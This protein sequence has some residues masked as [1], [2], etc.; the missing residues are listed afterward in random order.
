MNTDIVKGHWNEIKGKIKQQWGEFTDDEVTKM[1]GS[2]DELQGL[3]QKKYGDKKEEAEN[4][5]NDFLTKN[6]WKDE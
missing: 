5:L 4:H 2:Y 6:N 1:H 3:L